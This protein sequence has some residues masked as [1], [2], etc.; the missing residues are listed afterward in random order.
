M[1]MYILVVVAHSLFVTGDVGISTVAVV[2]DRA[3]KTK[4]SADCRRALD[5]AFLLYASSDVTDADRK[6]TVD[7]V[8]RV[9]SQLMSTRSVRNLLG[10]F[11]FDACRTKHVVLT[12]Y[13]HQSETLL[14]N[15]KQE[16][17]LSL[18]KADGTA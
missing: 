10:I 2:A 7:L 17:Q 9:S 11:L 13:C 16:A 3:A 14:Q 15:L 4:T 6:S 12:I 1:L 18:G 8:T 5:V